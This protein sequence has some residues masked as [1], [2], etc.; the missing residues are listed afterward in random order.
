MSASEYIIWVHLGECT[1]PIS[2][3]GVQGWRQGWTGVCVCEPGA[4][5]LL[6]V[7]PALGWGGLLPCL[8]SGDN[9]CLTCSLTK[10]VID[11][12]RLSNV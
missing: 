2:W 8:Q 3:V 10:T 1:R 9:T 6:S 4:R 12:K 11:M 5:L 7:S